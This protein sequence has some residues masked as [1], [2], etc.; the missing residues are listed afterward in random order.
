MKVKKLIETLKSL[1][2]DIDVYIPNN[3]LGDK[4]CLAFSITKSSLKHHLGAQED[5]I[6]IDVEEHKFTNLKNDKLV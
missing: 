2:G 5:F 6:I 1:D 4:Y 3:T